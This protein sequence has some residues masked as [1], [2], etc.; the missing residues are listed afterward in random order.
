MCSF[1]YF[2]YK[3]YL[4]IERN[5]IQLFADSFKQN[6]NFPAYTDYGSDNTL[7]YA[8][9]AVKVAELHILFEKLDLKQGD[10]ISLLGRN[11][12]SWALS[13]IATVTYGAVIVPI[14]HEFNPNDIKHIISHSDSKLLFAD[15][16]L[17]EKLDEENVVVENVISLNSFD[18]LI[19]PEEPI[20]KK[21]LKQLFS[22]KY[23]KGFT[24]ENVVYVER[25]N[26]EL[27]SINYT[28]GTT[29]YSK[30]VMCNGNALAGNVSFGIDTRLLSA[31]YDIVAFLP[32]AHAYGCAF[33]F[34]TATCTG[35]HI[36]IIVK[37]PTPQLLLEAFAEVRPNIIFSVPMIIE[38]IY[39]K[40]ILPTINNPVVAVLLKTPL[41][42]NV[43]RKKVCQK[44]KNAFGGNFSQII[45]GG[46]AVNPEAEEFFVK[47]RFPFT[48]GYGMTE[49]A[50][51]ISYTN[52][53]EFVPTSCGKIL[54]TM[55]VKIVDVNSETG[56]GEICVRGENLMDGYYK[57]EEAT[58]AAIDADGWLRTGD[59]GYV[60][61]SGTIY[62]RGRCKTMILSSSGQNIY[63]EEIESKLNLMP[64]I[65][66]SLVIGEEKRLVALVYPD[67][68]GLK[69]NGI[70]NKSLETLMENNRDNL[71]K[72]VAAY[73]R[74]SE[75]RIMKEE[76]E[77]TPKKSI[78][79]F[80]YQK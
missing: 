66:E 74:V 34:L 60:D 31:G 62:L 71:N 48:I 37:S 79:R 40:Q 8:D 30:G 39:K 22:E 45:V 33:D 24:K 63:P 52:Y 16:Y 67:M 54:P 64:Y 57:N 78:K 26:K 15:D 44:L 14:L 50:P 1:Y 35:C 28:S 10:K 49:C 2:C 65:A 61:D 29:G 42:G 76:F 38:K 18:F 27:A 32:F 58:S 19:N 3:F 68:A 9:V 23:P 25:S 70:D 21:T 56:T 12:T 20:D 13:Y 80:L 77:K 51:L 36:H 73:E 43:I 41:I 72:Q 47:I 59:L 75:I 53:T 69:D 17:W 46:A 5:F 55:E 11:S 4:M 7:T 6:W